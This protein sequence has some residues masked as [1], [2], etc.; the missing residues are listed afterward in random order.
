[1]V[2]GGVST[3]ARC[4]DVLHHGHGAIGARLIDSVTLRVHPRWAQREVTLQQG[5]LIALKAFVCFLRL[6]PRKP[7]KQPY[8]SLYQAHLL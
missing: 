3:A 2:N 8:C 4:H 7:E 5:I 6:P 1:M